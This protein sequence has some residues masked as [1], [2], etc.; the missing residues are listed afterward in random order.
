MNEFVLPLA[1]ARDAA[2]AG[3]KGTSLGELA[4][5]GVKVPPGFV[6]TAEA[7]SAALGVVDPGGARRAEISA[8]PATDLAAIT[9]AAAAFR[10][11]VVAAA[12]PPPVA[13]AIESAY[14]TLATCPVSAFVTCRV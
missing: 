6:I 1:E 2:S 7:F 5:A 11:Q 12:L 13:G 3:G 8:L 4:R 10:E 9:R 14:A